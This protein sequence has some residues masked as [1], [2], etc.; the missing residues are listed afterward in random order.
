MTFQ[1]HRLVVKTYERGRGPER[2]VK[3]VSP[4]YDY[5]LIDFPEPTIEGELRMV[6]PESTSLSDENSTQLSQMFVAVDLP[7][8]GLEWVRVSVTV[9]GQDKRTGRSWNHLAGLRTNS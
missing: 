2:A 7:G 6:I 9:S 1:P 4:G 5:A 3:I 8:T